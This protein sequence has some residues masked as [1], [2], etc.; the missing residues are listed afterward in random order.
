MGHEQSVSKTDKPGPGS[1]QPNDGKGI[2]A[3]GRSAS[4]SG[5]GG[6]GSRRGSAERGAGGS[7][8]GGGL[9]PGSYDIKNNLIGR[10]VA[11]SAPSYSMG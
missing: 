10:G 9:G 4:M 8:G 6:A 7:L 5:L 3:N 2:G 1:Y 11:P